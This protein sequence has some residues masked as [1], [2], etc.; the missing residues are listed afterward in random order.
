MNRLR[1]PLQTISASR[2]RGGSCVRRLADLPH[3]T[4]NVDIRPP[5]SARSPMVFVQKDMSIEM[6]KSP[7]SEEKDP[8]GEWVSE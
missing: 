3:S 7:W 1:V 4:P 6:T 5:P 8:N 2:A